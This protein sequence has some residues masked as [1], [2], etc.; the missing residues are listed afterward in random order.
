MKISARLS[1]L[2]AVI[3]PVFV[4]ISPDS[5]RSEV[6]LA[7]YSGKSVPDQSD[8]HLQ[9]GST[10]LTFKNVHWSDRSFQN[11]V[12]YGARVSYW[13]DEQPQSG[14]ALDFTHAKI[15]LAEEDRVKVRGVR[16][17]QAVSGTEPIADSINSFSLSHGLNML[18]VNA[19][20]RW[21]SNRSQSLP[22]QTH[23]YSGLGA[24]ISIPH[25]EADINGVKTER[26]QFA[27]GPVVNGL[28][29]LNY[30]VTKHLSAF[31]ELKLS[32]ADVNADLHGGGSIQTHAY[33]YQFIM[34][35][36]ANSGRK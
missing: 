16:N 10:D 35:L 24:G 31:L 20:Y 7:L 2:L 33:L 29:G 9:Q 30:E 23:F 13:F 4:V 18:T 1:L 11:P 5:A 26:Y 36:A 12:Y 32:F 6:S 19:L 28:V 27:A 15:Y 3:I 22:G 14:M 25:V 34:G 8:L 17:G 21:F